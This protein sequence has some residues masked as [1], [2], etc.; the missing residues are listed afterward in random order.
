MIAS[1]SLRRI[2]SIAAVLVPVAPAIGAAVLALRAGRGV[3]S[4]RSTGLVALA[5]LGLGFAAALLLASAWAGAGGEGLR[6]SL[7]GSAFF[8]DG[9]AAA[10]ATVTAATAFLVSRFS[11]RFLHRDPGFHRY[12]LLGLA[13]VAA[14]ELLVLAGS[15][16]LLVLGWGGVGLTSV[17]LGLHHGDRARAVD[18]ALRGL[19]TFRATDLGL[20]LAAILVRHSAGGPG[21]PWPEGLA[22]LQPEHAASVALLLLLASAGRSALLPFGGWLPSV[23]EGPAPATALFHTLTAHSGAYLLLRAIPVFEAS[24]VASIAAVVLGMVSAL[25]ATTITRVQSNANDRFA[26]A[27]MAQLGLMVVAVGLHLRSAGLVLLVAH[28][29]LRMY[30]LLRAPSALEDA[31]ELHEARLE[32]P[33]ARASLA[34]VWLPAPIRTRLYHRAL[35]RFHVDALLARVVLGPG[36]RLA[37]SL[38]PIGVRLAALPSAV[39]VVGPPVLSL[40]AALAAA[41]LAPTGLEALGTLSLVVAGVLA[42][43]ALGGLHLRPMLASGVVSQA[44]LLFAWIVAAPESDDEVLPLLVAGLATTVATGG[45]L[46]LDRMLGRR[47]RGLGLGRVHGLGVV[48]PGLATAFLV[49][50]LVAVVVPDLAA[51]LAAD[52][53]GSLLV[54]AAAVRTFVVLGIS[55]LHGIAYLRAYLLLFLG[56][57]DPRWL[58]PGVPDPRRRRSPG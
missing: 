50:V 21:V 40:G 20:V 41:R 19:V 2:A 58:A 17:F 22:S 5:A 26:F 48:W 31:R 18:G 24:P 39:L 4:E 38:A 56:P 15:V 25:L 28:L 8:V 51:F 53:S 12:F 1:E 45:L 37:R 49:L 10:M 43:A 29:V 36:R 23:M 52:R 14:M 9:L 32:L 35:H 7:H 47:T 30:Q 54:G 13:F 55:A 16:E 27:S 46:A 3:A 33:L 44:A 34:S 11:I 6:I 57:F 42:L